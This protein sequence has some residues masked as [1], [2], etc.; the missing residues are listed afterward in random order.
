MV[1]INPHFLGKI[2]L[3]VMQKKGWY[4]HLEGMDDSMLSQKIEH[5]QSESYSFVARY[6]EI[7][8]DGRKKVLLNISFGNVGGNVDWETILAKNVSRIRSVKHSTKRCS[9]ENKASE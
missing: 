2:H 5:Y 3:A 9:L 4:D 6:D 7:N 8:D 1:E